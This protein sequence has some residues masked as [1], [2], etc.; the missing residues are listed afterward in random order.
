[1]HFGQIKNNYFF[2]YCFENQINC[3]RRYSL[4]PL[5]LLT[6][7]L[8]FL[9]VSAF[10]LYCKHSF[11]LL[12]SYFFMPAP[13]KWNT[14]DGHSPVA[15]YL[16]QIAPLSPEVVK[17]I[18]ENTF[19]FSIEKRKL[20]L[21]PGSVADHF[22][23]IVKGVIH[24]FIKEDGKQITTWINEENE[25]V[26]SIRTLGTNNLCQ[27][28]LQALENCELVAIPL[29]FTESLFNKYPETNVIGRRLWEYNYRGAEERAYISR[30]PS[31]EKKYLH[32]LKT[33]PNLLNR[34]SLKYIASYLGMTLETL[35]RIRA[36]QN[37][38]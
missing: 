26:G 31:A 32:F 10:M 6:F 35:C 20:L 11:L 16:N 21:K 18:D 14:T 34:I 3:K 19:P 17:E 9:A 4:K 30:I 2:V 27:E 29:D 25:I 13:V 38:R 24:G 12:H 37:K 22:Y 33:Q 28:Y 7:L 1:M 15:G 5:I 23:F 8:K 36:R